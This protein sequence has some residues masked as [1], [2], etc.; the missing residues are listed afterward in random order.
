ME[1]NTTRRNNKFNNRNF[2][3]IMGTRVK[4]WFTS[5]LHFSHASILYFHPSRREAAGI[6]LEELQSDKIM[7]IEKHD[8]WL[9]NLW[10]STV[11]KEDNVYI[12]GDFCLGNKIRTEKILQRLHG[13]KFL[14]RGNHDKS[15]NGLE[16]YFEW[17]GDIK[18]VKFTNN[19]YDFIPAN[20][21]FAVELCHFPM[22]TWNRRPHGSCHAHGHCHGSVDSI[23]TAL[24]ELRV[25]VGLDGSLANYEFISLE[26][27]YN[28]MKGIA[29][30]FDCA[31]F[32]EY[33]DKKMEK[34]GYRA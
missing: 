2:R 15:C 29:E 14:I 6:T 27:L 4:T 5:D 8:E 33:I 21:T 19:Q 34:D 28:H 20:E 1:R 10:N 12:L 24:N 7:A 9:I 16:R 32:Q 22:M 31:T 23:N 30:S 13:K 25:D 11:D 18:E 17:V 26:K 3:I